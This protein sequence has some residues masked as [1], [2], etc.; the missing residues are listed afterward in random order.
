MLTPPMGPPSAP[1]E[2]NYQANM[3]TYA[4]YLQDE[5][6][7]HDD[8][9]LT[10]GV[11]ETWV[12]SELSDTDNP[13]LREED[14]SDSHPVV[15]MGLTYSG[16]EN[17]TLRGLFSQGYNFPNLQQ[18]FIGTVHGGR[19]PTL[20]NPDLAPET[21]NN[22]EAGVRFDNNALYFDIGAFMTRAEDYITTQLVQDGAAYR[23]S[24]IDK[25]E[26]YGVELASGYRIEPFHLTP[27]ATVAWLRSKFESGDFSTWE[28]GHPNLKGRIGLRFEKE[29][30]DRNVSLFTDL[31]SRFATE[32]E[33][34]FVSGEKETYDSWATANLTLGAYLGANRQYRFDLHLN[35]IFDKEY[36]MA[37][38]NL[39][40][41]GFHV[42]AKTTVTF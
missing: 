4:L 25:A 21:S 24:N 33:Q 23:Y 2:F 12:T 5:W 39:T 14:T 37:T 10:A 27:Y 32:A 6:D 30:E 20:P 15:S 41:A 11:R 34:E 36:T 13:E 16:G 42:V 31:Y 7:V 29:F 40:E 35:N 18:L 38:G 26:T 22:V 3:H 17:L 9:T 19:R 8:F 28:T 1:D